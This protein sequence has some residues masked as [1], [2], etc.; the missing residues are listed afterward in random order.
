M[1][2]FASLFWQGGQRSQTLRG[3]VEGARGM[4]QTEE[5]K[6][7]EPRK[8]KKKQQQCFQTKKVSCWQATERVLFALDNFQSNR[9]TNHKN[10]PY[11]IHELKLDF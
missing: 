4:D 10:Q 9:N 1:A 11:D 7:N 5:T 3:Y 6:N 8:L 2:N